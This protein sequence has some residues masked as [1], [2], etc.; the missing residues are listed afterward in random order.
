MPS[1]IAKR[2]CPDL[3]FVKP[4]FDAY[5]AISLQIREI[6]AE[7]TP[8]IEPL[9]LDEAYLDVTENLKG[10]PSAT[11]IAEE[12]RARIRAETEP[13]GVGRRLLQQVPR[14]TRLGPPQAGR[15]FRHHAENGA[16]IR[17]DAAG[18]EVS[19]HRAGDSREDGAARDRDR[20]RPQ[21]A[22]L[23]LSCST[24][25]GKRALIITGL[26]AASTSGPSAPTGYANPSAPRTRFPPI[27][28]PTKPRGMRFG[29]LSTRSGR[30]ARAPAFAAAPS[31]SR[32]SSPTFSRSRAAA[33]V[34]CRSGREANSNSSA[35][36]CSNRCFLSE[37][38]SAA[39]YLL[40]FTRGE[41]AEREPEFSLPV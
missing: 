18:Q 32:S 22:D 34:R 35:T 7:Y 8:I 3:I 30:T 11:Q 10:I 29:K 23:R 28:S 4:R 19:R 13:H 33:P 20:A 9:S 14:Q 12:I 16:G 27:F 38:Y 2:K 41:E 21:G 6:F 26:R 17:R 15:A 24:I 39:R 5:K 36:R 1:I 31:H 40:V 37:R 25:S